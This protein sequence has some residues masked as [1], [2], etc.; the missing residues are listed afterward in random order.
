MDHGEGN[1]G[2]TN[3]WDSR[4]ALDVV[5]Q[6]MDRIFVTFVCSAKMSLNLPVVYA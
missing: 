4:V 6:S 1:D 3:V 2:A 5:S